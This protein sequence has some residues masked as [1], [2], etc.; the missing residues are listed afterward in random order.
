MAATGQT[1]AVAAGGDLQAA[2]DQ[3]QSG[4]VITLEAGATFT[5]SFTLPKK[6]GDAFITI[7]TSA[8]DSA[9]PPVGT[10]VDPSFAAQLAK[11]VLPG[12]TGPAIGCAP[13]AHHYRL[14][15]LE[16]TPA[17]GTYVHR[18]IEIGSGESSDADLP[19]D[20]IVDRCY[21]HGDAVAGTRRG[22]QAN[23]K[24]VAIIDSYIADIKENGADSQAIGGWNG[25]GPFKIVNNHLEGAG[26]NLMF[27]GA[28]PTLSG[29][30]PSDIEFCHNH[31]VK[32]LSCKTENWTV[33][34]SFEL[35]N[36]QRVLVAGNVFDNNWAQ[37]RWASPSCSRRAVNAAR[38]PR[39]Q[40]VT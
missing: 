15:G 8:P 13:G 4:D 20:V 9:F 2:L 3:A 31:V 29:V 35:K 25:P 32:P 6:T 30:I 14:V 34:N 18:L 7:R 12:D 21:V 37:P 27:G 33:K 36:A 16:V 40:S 11:I 38:L 22:V 1:I 26:E 5:G 17:T 28:A 39:P 24:N 10:R 19:H 23:G